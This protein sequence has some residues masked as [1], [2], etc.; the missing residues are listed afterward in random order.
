[1][2]EFYGDKLRLVKESE[3]ERIVTG[4]F[5]SKHIQ[6]ELRFHQNV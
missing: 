5:S 6:L 1:M 2:D 4:S 3:L